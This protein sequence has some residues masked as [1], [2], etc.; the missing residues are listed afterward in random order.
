MLV[1]GRNAEFGDRTAD[2]DVLAIFPMIG[3]G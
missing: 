3:G 2:G 1:N